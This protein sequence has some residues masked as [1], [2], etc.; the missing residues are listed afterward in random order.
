MAE[1]YYIYY[2]RDIIQRVHDTVVAN[3]NPPQVK[4]RVSSEES[5]H[6]GKGVRSTQADRE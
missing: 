3:S 6:R 5:V 2:A 1:G 4:E